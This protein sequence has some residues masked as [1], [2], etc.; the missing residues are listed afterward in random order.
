MEWAVAMLMGNMMAHATV[1]T[2]PCACTNHS[3]TALQKNAETHKVALSLPVVAPLCPVLTCTPMTHMTAMLVGCCT[4]LL[5][6]L[7]TGACIECSTTYRKV[8]RW[9]LVQCAQ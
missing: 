2:T 3:D 6:H 4:Y 5:V 8:L 1:I 7:W 9:L